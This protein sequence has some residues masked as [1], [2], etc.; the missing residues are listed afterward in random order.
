MPRTWLILCVFLVIPSVLLGDSGL[1]RAPWLLQSG[2]RI[3]LRANARAQLSDE[4]AV[5]AAEPSLTIKGS[6]N[7]ELIMP[8]ELLQH[9][10]ANAYGD[11]SQARDAFRRTY[12]PHLQRSGFDSA[13]WD[14]LEA[15]V[16]PLLVIRRSARQ[17][18]R[19]FDHL[20]APERHQRTARLRVLE[21]DTCRERAAALEAARAELGPGFVRFLYEAVA[22]HM[23]MVVWGTALDSQHL[24]YVE[25]GCEQ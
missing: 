7:P 24:Q 18:A 11:D 19:E 15:I 5:P 3:A 10:L 21:H 25:R 4:A 13:F 8:W 12:E 9:L 17:L 1:D 14:E 22:P 6:E 20:S 2:D 16:R 23:T